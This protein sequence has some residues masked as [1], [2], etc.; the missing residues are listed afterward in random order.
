MNKIKFVLLAA[1]LGLALAFTLSCSNDDGSGGPTCSKI[2]SATLEGKT[3]QVGQCYD[4]SE[5]IL[6]SICEKIEFKYERNSK[7]PS[8]EKKKCKS[9]APFPGAILHEYG[10]SLICDN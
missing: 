7:C 3:Q 9:N 5:L 1:G 4:G 6:S 2:Y 10:E 8:G